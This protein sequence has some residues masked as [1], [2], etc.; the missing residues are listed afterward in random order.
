M[1]KVLI[2]DDQEES[3][4][5][6]RN[7]LMRSGPRPQSGADSSRQKTRSDCFFRTLSS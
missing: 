3:I 7:R 2:I 6:I 1:I 4:R 5:D